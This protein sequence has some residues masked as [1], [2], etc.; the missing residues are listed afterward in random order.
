MNKIL[1]RIEIKN[2]IECLKILGLYLINLI[3]SQA[4]CN[5]LNIL[6][7]IT[8]QKELHTLVTKMCFEKKLNDNNT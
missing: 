7:E 6:T 8:I 1:P 4:F 3:I 2:E 5:M